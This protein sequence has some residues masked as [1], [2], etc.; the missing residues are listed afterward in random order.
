MIVQV[1]NAHRNGDAGDIPNFE[2]MIAA[3]LANVLLNL[4][5]ELRGQITN[6]IR[7]G[8]GSSGG[9]SGA[10]PTEIHVWIKRFNNLKPF[11]F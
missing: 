6:D 9:G 3:A 2:A 5:T 7:N 4:S 11:A 1:E 10:P 8:A